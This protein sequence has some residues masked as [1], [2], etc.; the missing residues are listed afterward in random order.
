MNEK[1]KDIMYLIFLFI[2]DVLIV[3]SIYMK[4]YFPDVSIDELLFNLMFESTD[5]DFTPLFAA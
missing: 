1:I 2:I 5:S 4:V 3:A